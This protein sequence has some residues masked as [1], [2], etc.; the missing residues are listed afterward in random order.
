MKDTVFLAL[1]S[2]TAAVT[3][4]VVV[5]EAK[6][7][8]IPDEVLL[9]QVHDAINATDAA[10][11]IHTWN[12]GSE[13]IYGYTAEEILGQNVELL[14]FPEDR[15]W[16]R[17][18]VILAVVDRGQLQTTTRNRRK[19]GTEIYVALRLSVVRDSKGNVA[20]IIGC[21]NDITDRKKAEDSLR[22]EVA[23]RERVQ[24]ALA[25]SDARFR[26][27]LAQSPA[28]IYSSRAYDDYGATFV[29]EN[30][31]RLF[32]YPANDYL[33][34]PG[35]W[36][37][38]IH[39]EDREAVFSQL[40]LQLEAGKTLIEYRYL[41]ADGTYRWVRDS[42]VLI[43]DSDGQHLELVGH[44][45][46]VTKEREAREAQLEHE[47]L[48]F[49]SEALL[50]AQEE[51]RKRISRELHDDLNQRLA[52]LIMEMGLLG[53]KPPRTPEAAIQICDGL[54][55]QVADISDQVRRIALQLH[56]AGLEQFGL[57]TALGHECLAVADRAHIQVHYKTG[58]VPEKLPDNISLSLYRVAQECLRNIVKHADVTEAHV[59]LCGDDPRRIRLC[60]ED[61]GRGFLPKQARDRL[62]LGLIS[63]TERLRQVNGT[64]TIESEPGKGTRVEANVPFE[65]IPVLGQ[66]D[67]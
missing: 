64:L 43:R 1:P 13:R 47:R 37:D 32:G 10:G 12:S 35:F 19:D 58:G 62:T 54:K 25:A 39:P 48:Q 16:L 4:P 67:E 60:V 46:D 55:A 28:V 2:L 50:S 6:L 14:V 20:H 8:P 53:R 3:L 23:E 49:F 38:H 52:S 17:E 24:H 30:V 22:K 26:Y 9:D 15:E 27:L 31:Q 29:S 18:N 66:L 41:H 33:S 36:I 21:S 5:P 61:K 44:M 45:M 59:T 7:S 63:M 34:V 51:E 57:A 40:G 65:H 56:S 42:S 11:I